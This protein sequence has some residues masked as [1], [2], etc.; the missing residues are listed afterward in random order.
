MGLS[1]GSVRTPWDSRSSRQSVPLSAVSSGRR[2]CAR[3]QAPSPRLG[4]VVSLDTS[5]DSRRST[6]TGLFGPCGEDLAPRSETPRRVR[7]EVFDAPVTS[8]DAMRGY[9]NGVNEVM[10]A[11]LTV[12]YRLSPR[13]AAVCRKNHRKLCLCSKSVRRVEAHKWRELQ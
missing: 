10:H 1:A 4:I 3:W 5:S 7:V 13:F 9:P 2:T 11:H 8:T 12:D 6:T